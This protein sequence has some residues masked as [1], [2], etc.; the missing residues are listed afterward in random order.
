MTTRDL[1]SKND[2]LN[3]HQLLPNITTLGPYTRY[4]IWVQGCCR[5]CPGC[6]APDAQDPDGGRTMKVDD[7]V[8]KILRYSDHEGLTISGGEPFLQAPALCLVI[9]RIREERDCGVIIYTGFTLEELQGDQAPEG[10]LE[11][12]KRTDLLID[13]PY[14][15]E[16]NDDASLRGSSNQRIIPLTDRYKDQLNMYGVP[17]ERK[18]DVRWTEDGFFISGVPSKATARMQWPDRDV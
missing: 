6:I 10:A 11:L 1:P 5:Q 16:L 14:I 17:G 8:R 12:L 13:G 18:T 2:V 3:I 4:A 9:D 15:R 7:L